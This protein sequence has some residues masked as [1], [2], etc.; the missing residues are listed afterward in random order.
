MQLRIE[1]SSGSGCAYPEDQ[2]STR[3]VTDHATIHQ[4]FH[5]PVHALMVVIG[6]SWLLAQVSETQEAAS[7]HL[8]SD[9]NQL[10]ETFEQRGR[11]SRS[12]HEAA[13]ELNCSK[14]EIQE[15]N[16][17]GADKRTA[18]VENMTATNA[19]CA[20]CVRS[21]CGP[22]FKLQCMFACQHQRENQCSN[23]TGVAKI[24]S[25]ISRASLS[26]VESVLRMIKLVHADCGYCILETVESIC[27]KG[28]V[29]TVLHL[30]TD[31]PIIPRLCMPELASFLRM[32]N[33]RV[34][35]GCASQ[36]G[37]PIGLLERTA[38]GELFRINDGVSPLA[39][40]CAMRKMLGPRP[41]GN[42]ID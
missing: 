6:I 22:A 41:S 14:K 12:L 18:V 40:A 38:Q 27:G 7:I 30:T 34:D 33:D 5:A 9:A 13:I 37:D 8:R 10:N 19:A 17:A 3:T 2:I 25:L 23:S 20:T 28:C 11:P 26:D 24:S 35:D 39:V 15:V 42:P 16:G 4:H 32:G 1:G 31:W 36:S 29:Q 21:N